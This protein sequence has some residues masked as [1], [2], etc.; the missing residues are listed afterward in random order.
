MHLND[1]DKDLAMLIALLHDI[2]R[3]DQAKQMKFFREDL[4]NYDHAKLEVKLLFES[5]EIRKFIKTDKYDNVIK[6]GY[7]KS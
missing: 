5:G 4:M 2:G 7:C 3:F 1:E 6:K